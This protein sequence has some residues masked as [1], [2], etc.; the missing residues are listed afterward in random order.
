M[1]TARVDSHLL[2]W[3][4]VD[5]DATYTR[6][7]TGVPVEMAVAE[8]LRKSL[9]ATPRKHV[10]VINTEFGKPYTLDG[11]SRFM[12]RVI[13]SG[14]RAPAGIAVVHFVASISTAYRLRA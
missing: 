13:D 2:T 11:F 7:K 3:G 14:G 1:G 10:T 8:N 9:L 12:A 6:Q 5:T 4:Q